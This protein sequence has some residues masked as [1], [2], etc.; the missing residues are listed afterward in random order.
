M[1]VQCVADFW[2]MGSMHSY[3]EVLIVDDAGP[4]LRDGVVVPYV[5][6]EI[7]EPEPAPIL[8]TASVPVLEPKTKKGK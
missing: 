4:W 3:G 5:E 6:P 8:E 2:G 7:V 1:K